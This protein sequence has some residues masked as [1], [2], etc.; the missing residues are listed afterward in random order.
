MIWIRIVTIVLAY[1]A[2]LI[3]VAVVSIPPHG[4]RES[5]E[6]RAL[7]QGSRMIRISIYQGIF[8]V[9]SD[10]YILVI[11]MHL[12]VRLRLPISKK[13]AVCGIFVS[14]LLYALYLNHSLLH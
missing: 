11:P 8:G 12:V 14:G 10:F 9:I 6:V 2:F 4:Q 3:A 7:S 5:S 13:A 1:L